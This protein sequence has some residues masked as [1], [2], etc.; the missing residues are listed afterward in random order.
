MTCLDNQPL[1]AVAAKRVAEGRQ[2]GCHY[3]EGTC[4]E[5]LAIAE[6]VL[7][8]VFPKEPSTHFLTLML[9]AMRYSYSPLGPLR[10]MSPGYPAMKAIYRSLPVWRVLWTEK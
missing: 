2:H 7:C 8:A 4:P 1:I 3:A 10:W 9:S 6:A 5:C